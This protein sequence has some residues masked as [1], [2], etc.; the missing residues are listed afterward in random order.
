MNTSFTE[1]RF[2][3]LP[4]RQAS[5]SAFSVGFS[6]QRN[7]TRETVFKIFP[8]GANKIPLIK[9]WQQA[10]T[11][12]PEQIRLWQELFKDKLAYWGIPT[13]PG[14]DLLVLDVDVKKSNGF[15]SLKALPIPETMTQTTRSGGKHYLFRYPKDGKHY[16]N[17]AGFLPGLDI[18]GEGGYIVHYGVDSK[19]IADAPTWLLTDTAKPIYQA[20]GPTVK[21]APEIAQA[22]VLNSLEAIRNA[23]EGESNNTL[24]TE[25][26]KV[27][28]LVASQ[29]ITREYAF[30]T[31][32]K[33]AKDRG[34]PDYEAKA[35]INSGLD[36]GSKKPITSPFGEAPPVA[37]IEIPAAPQAPARWTPQYFT[38]HDLMNTS[39]LKKPQL[40]QDWS[41]EDIHIT[42]AD[43]GTGK[44]TLKLYEAICLALGER[45]LGFDCKQA[46]KTLFITGEDTDKKLAAMLGAI[47]RQMGLFE[48]GVGNHEKIQT[49]LQSIVIKKDADLCLIMK[50]KQGFLHPNPDA[51]RKV[52][53]AVEDIKP[54]MIVFDPISSFWG[55]ESALNDMNKA[56]I[57]FMSQVQEASHA[58][59]EMINHMGKVSSASKD[60]SQ[61]AGRGGTGLPS[62]SRVSRV[63]RTVF[64]DE[65]R[66][67]TGE[68]LPDGT[69]AILCNVNKFTDGSPL[70]NKPFLILRSGYLFSRKALTKAK[71]QEAERALTDVERV[72]AF[73]KEC[74]NDGKYPTRNVVIGHFA[75]AGDPLSSERVK[76]A[77]DLL[78]FG[79]HMGERIKQVENPDLTIKDKVFVITDMGGKEL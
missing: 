19:P 30:E 33:A 48:E 7:Q 57:K 64:E 43:G 60:M 20:T 68:E 44:T 59:V 52:M 71:A 46:G 27:G 9:G 40:F 42:T 74:R 79:G 5:V 32:F 28:Q 8:C 35:T 22:I 69:T 58:C 24:N 13:G 3:S 45:F 4:D 37:Q 21:V 31:L 78:Q 56:V 25:A 38:R 23:P 12:D 2:G 63:L 50:D 36:G 54:K 29:S 70:Y 15:E 47:V 11:T 73:I 49:I 34:K 75:V 51:M 66:E 53:E 6:N 62:N 77:I 61:F 76:R 18:R 39:K 17:R 26:F 14:T 1:N 65:F 55:S 72:F 16:G 41:T 10:A 67:L